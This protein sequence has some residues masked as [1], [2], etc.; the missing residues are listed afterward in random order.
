MKMKKYNIIILILLALSA[1]IFIVGTVG[2][3]SQLSVYLGLTSQLSVYLGLTV[4]GVELM[5]IIL[6][7]ADTI[8]Q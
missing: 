8:T 1:L 5:A 2:L 7:I 6:Y 3:A 4:L